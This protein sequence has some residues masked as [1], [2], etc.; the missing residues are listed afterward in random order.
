MSR[1]A[2][3]VIGTFALVFVGTGAII[4]NDVTGGM[5][6][7]FGVALAFGLVVMT[8]INSVGD[9]S[10]AHFNP[11]VSLAFFLAGKLEAR[12]VM[13]Y[14]A[15]QIAGAV[16][17]SGLLALL[18]AD[19]A[20]LGATLPTVGVAEAFLLEVVISFFLMFVILGVVSGPRENA[21]IAGFAIGATV[22]MCALVAGPL[23][24]GSMNPARSLAPALVGGELASLWI[25]LTAPIIGTTMAV[26]GC[27]AVRGPECCSRAES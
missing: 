2:A 21:A 16:A 19:H 26:G 17:A 8:M 15:S 20:T 6:T 22:C 5:V 24:G 1:Y 27:R 13:P 12:E 14:I 7:H 10:G 25:Y 4:V 9:V 3:E 18:F 23:T 11:A